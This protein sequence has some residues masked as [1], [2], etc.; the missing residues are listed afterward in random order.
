MGHHLILMILLCWAYSIDMMIQTSIIQKQDREIG[1]GGK[2]VFFFYPKGAGDHSVVVIIAQAQSFK[3][4]CVYI[5]STLT[6]TTCA[7]SM[8]RFL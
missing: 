7:L 5:D 8:F 3:Y 1:V 4:L 6:W 2:S